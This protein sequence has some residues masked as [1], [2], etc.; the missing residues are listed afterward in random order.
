MEAILS[1]VTAAGGKI[2]KQDDENKYLWV[3]FKTRGPFNVIN[4]DDV[5]F[6]IPP[7]DG[8]VSVRAAARRSGRPDGGRNAARLEDLRKSLGWDEVPILRN[9]RRRFFIIE[10]PWDDFGP[11]P[12]PSLDYQLDLDQDQ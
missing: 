9:R 7:G 4:T 1:A 8:T 5:E 6:L 12:P 3:T 2:Q 10:S 11:P